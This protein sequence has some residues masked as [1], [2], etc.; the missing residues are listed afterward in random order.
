M[1]VWI[2][3]WAL[4]MT[5]IVLLNVAKMRRRSRR[6]G[7]R[8]RR[9][10]AS[11]SWS[12]VFPTGDLPD[13]SSHHGTSHHGGHDSGSSGGSSWGSWG[14]WGSDSGSS[15][16]SSD[17]GSSWGGSDGGSSSSSC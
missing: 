8:Y 7:A 10:T 11:D 15:W 12:G 6:S 5:M 4:W 16:G 3:L 13:G 14:S 17:G 9:G 2:V 1:Y